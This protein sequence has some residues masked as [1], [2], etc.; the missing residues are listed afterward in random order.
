MAS[1]APTVALLPATRAL[2]L[3]RPLTE[4]TVA[5]V[6]RGEIGRHAPLMMQRVVRYLGAQMLFHAMVYRRFDPALWLRRSLLRKEP[7]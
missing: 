5:E 7:R 6:E 3:S 2:G 1:V 4:I